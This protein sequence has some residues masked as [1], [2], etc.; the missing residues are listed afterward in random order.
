MAYVFWGSIFN[1]LAV[2]FNGNGSI[3]NS[4]GGYLIKVA[5]F[6]RSVFLMVKAVF[7]KLQL[8]V[9]YCFW[10]YFNK[11]GSEFIDLAVINSIFGGKKQK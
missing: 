5:V 1:T 2:F 6:H 11:I 10:Q 4:I 8:A 9:F 7:S 3:F